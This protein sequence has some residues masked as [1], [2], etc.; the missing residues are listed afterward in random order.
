MT[1]CQLQND[2]SRPIITTNTTEDLGGSIGSPSANLWW[3]E[4]D[5]IATVGMGGG[6]ADTSYP[7]SESQ[8][9]SD[10]L[11]TNE[12][13]TTL[14]DYAIVDDYLTYE[15]KAASAWPSV[16]VRRLNHTYDFDL[17]LNSA[18]SNPS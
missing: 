4:G 2:E 17:D 10:L 9:L 18:S 12:Y 14:G 11:V 16:P 7:R 1:G 3:A 5:K 6:F 15:S 13:Q 8:K